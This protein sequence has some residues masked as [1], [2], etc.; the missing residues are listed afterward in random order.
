MT[1]KARREAAAQHKADGYILSCIEPY[2]RCAMTSLL[3]AS[4][5]HQAAKRAWQPAGGDV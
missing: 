5:P 1:K 4:D 3:G 2:G